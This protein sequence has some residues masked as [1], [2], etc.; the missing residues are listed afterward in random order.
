MGQRG[1]KGQGR[2]SGNQGVTNSLIDQCGS[3]EIQSDKELRTERQIRVG[4]YTVKK[5]RRNKGIKRQTQSQKWE[6][7]T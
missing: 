5:G 7:E 4:C 2:V 1:K 3:R 6:T